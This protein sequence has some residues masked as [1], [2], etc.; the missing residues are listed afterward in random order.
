LQAGYGN[1]EVGC[2]ECNCSRV[3]SVDY[4]CHPVTGQCVCRPGVTGLTCDSCQ[5]GYYGYSHH[6]CQ[7]E[8]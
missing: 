3:G 5:P 6:G 4:R 7:G 2:R 8:T 1:V